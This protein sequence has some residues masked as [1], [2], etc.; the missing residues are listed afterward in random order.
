MEG[1]MVGGYGCVGGV[2]PKLLRLLLY[3]KRGWKL[4]VFSV[5][6]DAERSCVVR[7]RVWNILS[8]IAFKK[9]R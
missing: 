7:R 5:N 6:V 2:R 8:R 1:W 9:N 4:G 3:S